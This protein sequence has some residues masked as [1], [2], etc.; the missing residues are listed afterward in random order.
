MTSIAERILLK[1]GL[2]IYEPEEV[3]AEGYVE[4]KPYVRPPYLPYEL[5]RLIWK[6]KRQNHMKDRIAKL[7]SILKFQKMITPPE[8]EGAEYYVA[9]IADHVWFTYE[10]VEFYQQGTD[11]LHSN[12]ARRFLYKNAK[13]GVVFVEY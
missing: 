9:T 12:K 4:P 5:I 6:F 10:Q 7:E 3:I 1:R 13:G 8:D 11:I 2:T